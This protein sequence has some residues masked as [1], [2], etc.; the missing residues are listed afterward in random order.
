MNFIQTNLQDVYLI[1]LNKIEDERGFFA[2]S[3]CSNEFKKYNLNPN[4]VQQNISNSYQLHTLRGMHYQIGKYAED[5]YIRCHKGSIQDVIIDLRKNST[6]YLQHQSFNLSEKNYTGLY[7]PKGFAHGFITLAEDVVV[8]Y[9][10]SS[11]YDSKSERAIRWNDPLFSIDWPTPSPV[12]SE[13]DSNLAN[14]NSIK[15]GLNNNYL[16]SDE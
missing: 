14:F 13:K 10:V 6:T 1:A 5:K 4:F 11:N 3:F 12:I 7:V 16:D 8:S 15:N 2:R 9:L